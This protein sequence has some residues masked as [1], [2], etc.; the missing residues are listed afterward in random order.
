MDR[1]LQH[2][3]TEL[4][5]ETKPGGFVPYTM[6]PA[7]EHAL[8]RQLGPD[9]KFQLPPRQRAGFV[10][11]LPWV[12]LLLL[13]LQLGGVLLVLGLSA[14]AKLMGAGSIFPAVISVVTFALDLI[15]LPGLFAGT[16]KGWTFFAYAIAVGALSNVISMSLLGLLMSALMLWLAFQ[17]KYEYR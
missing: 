10:R 15:A 7:L 9:S 2:P 12:A 5:V 3:M 17:V 13:P 8:E 14:V 16:R 11:F 6:F 1:P 4:E